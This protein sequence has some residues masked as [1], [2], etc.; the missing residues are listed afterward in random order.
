MTL[1]YQF[2]IKMKQFVYY[3]F[4]SDRGGLGLNCNSVLLENN[5]EYSNDHFVL[6]LDFAIYYISILWKMDLKD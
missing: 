6:I 2:K 1:A 5:W 3:Q 4:L